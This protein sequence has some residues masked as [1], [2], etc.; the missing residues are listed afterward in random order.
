[1]ALAMTTSALCMS[2]RVYR[3]NRCFLASQARSPRRV[4][5]WCL[6]QDDLTLGNPWYRAAAELRERSRKK[7]SCPSGGRG[8]A[9]SAGCARTGVNLSGRYGGCSRER[10]ISQRVYV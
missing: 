7:G 1:M 2:T 5:Q 9:L 3:I 6:A 8:R 10:D 4:K